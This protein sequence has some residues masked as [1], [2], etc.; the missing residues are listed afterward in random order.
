MQTGSHYRDECGT[1]S[2]A[3][4]AETRFNDLNLCIE[5]WVDILIIV[6]SRKK[7]EIYTHSISTQIRHTYTQTNVMVFKGA[8]IC[9]DIN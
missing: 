3:S 1:S 2:D 7:S 4:S 6:K 9:K 5:T 8:S